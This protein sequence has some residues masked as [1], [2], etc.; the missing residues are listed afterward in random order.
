[1]IIICVVLCDEEVRGGKV[2]ELPFYGLLSAAAA[3]AWLSS[4]ALEFNLELVCVLAT[5]PPQDTARIGSEESS[6][7]KRLGLLNSKSGGGAT[8]KQF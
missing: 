5:M 7:A 4:L 2:A 6:G 3:A 1:V 8:T